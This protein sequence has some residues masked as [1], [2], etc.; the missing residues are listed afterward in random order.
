MELRLCWAAGTV[1]GAARRGRGF[2]PGGTV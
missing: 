2:P 1:C